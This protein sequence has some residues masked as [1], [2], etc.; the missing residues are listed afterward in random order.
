MV[1]LA[2]VGAGRLLGL[3]SRHCRMYWASGAGV[4]RNSRLV[5]PP[6]LRS[7]TVNSS[8]ECALAE[9]WGAFG[10]FIRVEPRA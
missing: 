5:G 9:W 6:R 4:L 10:E 8:A 1:A 3:G 7:A 2:C